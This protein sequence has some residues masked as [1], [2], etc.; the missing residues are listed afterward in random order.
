MPHPRQS[1]DTEANTST[2]KPGGLA[3]EAFLRSIKREDIDAH[4]PAYHEPRFSSDGFREPDRR[5]S[6]ITSLSRFY[7]EHGMGRHSSTSSDGVESF[8]WLPGGSFTHPANSGALYNFWPSITE[9]SPLGRLPAGDQPAPLPHSRNISVGKSHG[10]VGAPSG[11]DSFPWRQASFPGVSQAASFTGSA[12]PALSFTA[13][14]Q[15]TR[16]LISS[17]AGEPSV[18]SIAEAQV[19]AHLREAQRLLASTGDKFPTNKHLQELLSGAENSICEDA[20]RASSNVNRTCQEAERRA[21][22]AGEGPRH[23]T[24]LPPYPTLV[25][26]AAS[27]DSFSAALRDRAAA[28]YLA[29]MQQHAAQT[30]HHWLNAAR[31]LGSS[32]FL[33]IDHSDHL[34]LE[35]SGAKWQ[36]RADGSFDAVAPASPSDRP[37]CEESPATSSGGRSPGLRSEAAAGAT[38]L[39]KRRAGDMQKTPKHMTCHVCQETFPIETVKPYLRCRRICAACCYAPVCVSKDGKAVKFCQLCSKAHDASDFDPGRRSCR[40][41]LR[42]H[43]QR[44]REHRRSSATPSCVATL[45]V[46]HSSDHESG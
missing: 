33:P 43:A 11:T 20:G 31:S 29:A 21:S 4:R 36:R 23:P 26:S 12:G 17:A 22:S 19:L 39:K 40:A 2:P 24:A 1:T 41:E 37:G 28:G 9:W 32:R 3:A 6:S 30:Q 13:A 14:D 10:Q 7:P 15:E 46:S 45:A 25:G 35:S 42:K 38:S 27:M 44:R 16:K 8:F 5:S 34:S 18:S